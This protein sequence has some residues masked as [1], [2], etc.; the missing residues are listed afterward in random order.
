MIVDQPDLEA[1]VWQNIKHHRGVTSFAYSALQDVAGYQWEHAIQVDV[2]GP[3]KKATR[4]EAELVRK[5]LLGLADLDWP[6]GQITYAQ[7]TV[8]PFWNPDVND[9]APRYTMRIDFRVHPSK[10]LATSS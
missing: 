5:E 7:V 9:G 3:Q 2:R 8:G 4:D 10:Q 1:W 6:D